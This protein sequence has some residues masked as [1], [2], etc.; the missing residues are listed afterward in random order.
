M[1]ISLFET[2]RSPYYILAP[3]FRHSSAGIRNLHYLC[4]VLNE[5]GYE[6]YIAGAKTTSIHLRTPLLD[7]RTAEQ[8]FCSG[9]TPIA[10]YPEIIS[11][12]PIN[13]P[14]V[15]RWLLNI[16]GHLGGDTLF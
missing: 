5:L 6:A 12:N 3:D 13:T 10:V 11:G 14:V 1:E 8:H 7:I 2:R 9:K 4:H 16:P 15:A